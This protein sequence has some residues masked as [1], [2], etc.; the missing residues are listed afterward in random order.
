[1]ENVASTIDFSGLITAFQGVVTPA[2]LLTILASAIGV[3]ASFVLMWFGVRK[4][5][6]VFTKAFTNGK[7]SA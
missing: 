3:G 1:M 5:T 4:I 6:K 2:Q 7:L